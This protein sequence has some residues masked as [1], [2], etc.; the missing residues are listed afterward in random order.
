MKAK[1]SATF[2]IGVCSV[3]NDTN[4]SAFDIALRWR[5]RDEAG[6]ELLKGEEQMMRA[7]THCHLIGSGDEC[8]LREVR[9]PFRYHSHATKISFG[10]SRKFKIANSGSGGNQFW[11]TIVLPQTDQIHWLNFMRR[12]RRFDVE[13]HDTEFLKLWRTRG[14]IQPAQ[15]HRWFK[16]QVK[17]TAKMIAALRNQ[18][19]VEM[20]EQRRAELLAQ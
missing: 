14:S 19:L 15:L 9:F 3:D 6:Q 4:L 16:D 11:E 13:E 5:I 20:L 1:I 2:I 8:D 17:I 10:N 18:T 12:Q 7:T